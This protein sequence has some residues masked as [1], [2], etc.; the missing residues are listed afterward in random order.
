MADTLEKQELKQRV[1]AR[2]KDLEAS[3]HRLEAEGSDKAKDT[4]ERVKDS[5]A[6]LETTLREGWDN[7]SDAAAERVNDWLSRNEQNGNK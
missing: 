6:E 5:L 2:K 4:A 3:L 7:L 1:L